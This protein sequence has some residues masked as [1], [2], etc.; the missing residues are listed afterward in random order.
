MLQGGACRQKAVPVMWAA[1]AVATTASGMV[2]ALASADE[3]TEPVREA[4]C[5]EQKEGDPPPHP[6]PS[7]A[8]SSIVSSLPFSTAEQAMARGSAKNLVA[9]ARAG[10][11]SDNVAR[12][13]SH[14]VT[15]CWR[16]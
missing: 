1:M 4:C 6:C 5:G 3:A 12:F 8:Q 7:A 14:G 11:D 13:I 16:R 15:R 9:R 2:Q 10:E